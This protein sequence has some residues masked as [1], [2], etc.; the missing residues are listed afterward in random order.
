MQVS[1]GCLIRSTITATHNEAVM[2]YDPVFSHQPSDFQTSGT[3]SKNASKIE[4]VK[5]PQGTYINSNNPE[6]LTDAD[7]NQA[8]T[9][10]NVTGEVFFT[11]E[12]NNGPTS[13]FYYGYQVKNTTDHNLYITIKNLG[14]QLDGPGSWLGQ[15][16]WI[17]FYN[18]K[19]DYDTTKWSEQQKEIF[20]AYYNFSSDYQPELYQPLTVVLPPNEKIYVMGG[21]TKDSFMNFN[22]FN[23]ANKTVRGGCSNAA[24]LFNV[25]GGYAQATFYVYTNPDLIAVE[26]VHQG[27]VVSRDD[28]D[29]GSQYIGYDTCNGI[30]ENEMVFSF[31]DTTISNKLPVTF[32]SY[33]KDHVSAKGNP[34]E[35][36][37]STAHQNTLFTWYTHINPQ[38]NST[39]VGTDMTRYITIDAITKEEVV[40]DSDHYDG[41]GNLANIGNWMIDY[42][43]R[44]NFVNQGSR[45]RKIT[46]GFRDGGSVAVM[47]RDA[48]GKI[49]DKKFTFT[50]VETFPFNNESFSYLYTLDIPA[51]TVVQI[52]MEY[53]LLANSNGGIRHMV[54]L[55]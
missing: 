26:K 14:F 17:Q 46:L 45:N 44:Y 10:N 7:L 18:T 32:T 53:N 22:C 16:E 13:S 33:Y 15:N 20:I 50:S 49:L 19:F 30:V 9:R 51:H 23:T 12:H 6:L 2:P 21:T 28:K 42:Q 11:F 54:Y 31:D 55:S 8:L 52:V 36:I 35:K 4:Y 41:K 3:A 34:Y 25:A 48:N 27:Y 47:M 39:A 1:K 38:Y 24:V 37:D 29:F 43:D 40:I 5:R